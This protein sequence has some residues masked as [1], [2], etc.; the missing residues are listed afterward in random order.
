MANDL[1]ASLVSMSKKEYRK[2]KRQKRKRNPPKIEQQ[3]QEYDIT[4]ELKCDTLVGDMRIQSESQL[5]TI[6]ELIP[7]SFPSSEPLALSPN[8]HGSMSPRKQTLKRHENNN[9]QEPEPEFL[10]EAKKNM[11]S[12]QLINSS[13]GSDANC[14]NRAFQFTNQNMDGKSTIITIPQSQIIVYHDLHQT[15]EAKFA[16]GNLLACGVLEIFQLHKCDVTYMSCGE[17]FVYPLLPKL[18]ILRTSD[19]NFVLPLA[20]PRRYW[21]II[22]GTVDQNLIARLE[23]VLRSVVRY[24]NLV[25]M[26]APSLSEDRAGRDS[27]PRLPSPNVMTN[28]ILS[29]LFD[30]VPPSPP[31]VAAS[32]PP[33]LA[34]L[35]NLD[36]DSFKLQ[37]KKNFFGLNRAHADDKLQQKYSQPVHTSN[38]Q[39]NHSQLHG[40]MSRLENVNNN[41]INETSSMDLL[42][43]EYE[44]TLSLTQSVSCQ[45]GLSNMPSLPKESLKFPTL[46]STRGS[47]YRFKME[48]SPIDHDW[49]QFPRSA[50]RLPQRRPNQSLGGRSR[51]SST[52]DLYA[53][54]SNWMEPGQ[55]KYNSTIP[56]SRSIHSFASRQSLSAQDD[57]FNACR[58]FSIATYSSL[59]REKI[60]YNHSLKSHTSPW[61]CNSHLN[62]KKCAVKAH[63]SK[64]ISSFNDVSVHILPKNDGL[65]P[66]EVYNLIRN[67]DS[68]TKPKS[69]GIRGL[70]GW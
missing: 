52:S 65:T 48:T 60:K 37:D 5:H 19:L 45:E 6:A 43:E 69:S 51:K 50:G 32:P 14:L 53:S 56:H 34:S 13:A 41:D 11:K 26:S 40:A 35:S 68:T 1:T 27:S 2:K 55:Q 47:P 3:T 49:S 10:S 31:S 38:S 9:R 58:D 54:I 30:E 15:D 20:N 63:V 42:L 57:S 24:T 46:S 25:S 17:S 39:N 66:S 28:Q 64:K 4:T 8:L 61:S 23:N 21:K 36:G 67:R 62:G 22:L 12:T 44:E 59:L 29:S 18:N 7:P 16:L 70:F 33:Y